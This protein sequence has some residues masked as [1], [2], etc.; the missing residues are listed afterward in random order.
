MAEITKELGRISVTR[1]EYEASITY[2]KDNI[3]QYKR[4]SYQ[5]V[6]ESPIVGVPP[7]NDKNIVNPGWTLFAGT[8]DAQDVVNQIKEQEA[9]SIQ[10]VADREAEI[11][12]KSDAA[13]VSF[14]NTG[15]SLSGTNVQDALKETDSKINQLKNAGYLY[16]GIATPST[17]PGTPEGH[18]FYIANGKGTYTNFGS[19]EVTEDEVVVL[20]Y[21][22][23][24]HKEATGIASNDKLTVLDGQIN[25][26]HKS[27]VSNRRNTI[28][29]F[30]VKVGEQYKIVLEGLSVDEIDL[31]VASINEL[32]QAI[33][34]FGR[35][36]TLGEIKE[37]I[38]STDASRIE[39]YDYS[40]TG[41][42][43]TIGF[44][45]KSKL[46]KELKSIT[47]DI[48]ALAEADIIFNNSLYLLKNGSKN[49]E[50]NW[51]P[52]TY[53]D[54][55]GFAVEASSL[56]AA[57]KDYLP[58]TNGN[59]YQIKCYAPG[60][61]DVCAI[62][63]KNKTFISYFKCYGNYEFIAD[64]DGF[65]RISTEVNYISTDNCFIIEKTDRN[66]QT[67]DSEIPIKNNLEYIAAE[68]A[69]KLIVSDYISLFTDIHVSITTLKA[70]SFIFVKGYDENDNYIAKYGK[71][72]NTAGKTFD[73]IFKLDKNISY[74]KFFTH[75][76]SN[77]LSI[78]GI[79][80]YFNSQ[81][82]DNDINHY[83]Y[84]CDNAEALLSIMDK[85]INDTSNTRPGY[86]N[87]YTVK[88]ASGIYNVDTSS[89]VHHNIILMPFVKL[90]GAGMSE[91][92]LEYMYEG[93]D[94]NVMK[95]H[96]GINMPYTST[97]EDL[98]IRVKN[99]R[100]AVHADSGALPS[101]FNYDNHIVANRCHFIHY[102]FEDGYNPSYKSP[103]AWG[104]GIRYGSSRIFNDCIFESYQLA[105]F[106]L[107]NSTDMTEE[108][109]IAFDR[110]KF[111]FNKDIDSFVNPYNN[112][113]AVFSNQADNQSIGRV[114]MTDCILDRYVY[115]HGNTTDWD[116]SINNNII[117]ICGNNDYSKLHFGSKIMHFTSEINKGTPIVI[118]GINSG[119]IYTQELHDS[120]IGILV[121]NVSANKNGYLYKSGDIIS[122]QHVLGS[123]FPTGTTLG[124]NN[125]TW[126]EDSVK[127]LVVA[128][129]NMLAKVL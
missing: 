67:I 56:F 68:N 47:N 7:T 106:F 126:V 52:N 81:D 95:V 79:K 116:I 3:V 63:D 115:V 129:S 82:I 38:I 66:L 110:C 33:Q 34:S 20:Y 77:P 29:N 123:V 13:E 119:D 93:S 30:P 40:D 118:S 64:T 46:S 73:F 5:V 113:D 12:T 112:A 22:K 83:E 78:Y 57:V 60:S 117:V 48:N 31:S 23:E 105:P 70:D 16:A 19:I 21:D 120:F 41:A 37:V 72:D 76:S 50:L 62:Y 103:N 39:C 97:I 125:G 54:S 71:G 44:I 122:M 86:N 8:L 101:Q 109:Y 1:G 9:K 55:A 14:N 43:Y 45:R 80:K 128:I 74:L 98:T 17:N 127:P 59:I 69:Y 94:T 96:S 75:S 84:F 25:D 107:H 121:Q 124:Y 28:L 49:L 11:L 27:F 24:W 18:V 114:V 35:L 90:S 4:G 65:I 10:A 87:R 111:I 108:I 91:T 89:G 85:L 26:L 104:S 99:I 102:G 92:V 100:Y 58:I 15:T 61:A 88:L 2:Y 42:E 51:T 32:N 53:I 6:S 36:K